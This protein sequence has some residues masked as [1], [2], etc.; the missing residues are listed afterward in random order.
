[1]SILP[2]ILQKVVGIPYYHQNAG[3]FLV[4][5]ILAFGLQSPPSLLVSPL[6]LMDAVLSPVFITAILLLFFLYYLKCFN[7]IN[8]TLNAPENSFLQVAALLP[9]QTLLYYLA[10]AHVL[11]Y[12]PALAYTLLMVGY[13]AWQQHYQT[14]FIILLY[15]MV[16]TTLSAVLFYQKLTNVPTDK[17]LNLLPKISLLPEF[18][19][20]YV[21]TLR[22]LL[23]QEKVM[24]FL[25]KLFSGSVLLA[26]LYLYPYP[27]YDLR[28][29]LIGFWTAVVS[30]VMLVQRVQ[31]F[32]EEDLTFLRNLPYSRRQ[33]LGQQAVFYSLCLV[34]E[35]ILLLRFLP[36]SASLFMMQLG[37]LG[38][39]FLLLMHALLYLKDQ[40]LRKFSRQVFFIF[41]GFLLL[42]LTSPPLYLLSINLTAIA[43]S[44]YYQ[45]YYAYEPE[46]LEP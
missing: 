33:R 2:V 12:L 41:M 44:I 5:F 15:N 7:F 40:S 17:K 13:A 43:Y 6:F 35:L 23:E 27:A 9:P 46:E 1:M 36:L 24:L 4:V 26:F 37:A 25:T 29:A 18:N 21:W 16:L 38:I 11:L 8:K 3:F 39:S 42:F 20:V 14:A 19:K 45:R 34:P 28:P 31:L 32:G 30:H 10:R 22:Y